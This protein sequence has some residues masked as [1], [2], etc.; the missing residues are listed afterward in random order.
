MNESVISIALE[1]SAIW[2]V[3]GRCLGY[4]RHPQRPRQHA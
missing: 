2:R 1:A 3:T 4:L